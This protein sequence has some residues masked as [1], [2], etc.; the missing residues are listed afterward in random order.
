VH[1][2]WLS[3]LWVRIW[4][5]LGGSTVKELPNHNLS[6]AYLVKGLLQSCVV[7][8]R[9]P[10]TVVDFRASGLHCLLAGDLMWLL[11]PLGHPGTDELL[12]VEAPRPCAF[13]PS[14]L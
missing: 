11:T 3:D 2:Q 6:D 4:F 8:G 7:V 10:F 14:S 1:I 5:S 13:F 12:R 9:I